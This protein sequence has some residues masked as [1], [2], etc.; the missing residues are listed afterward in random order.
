M[1]VNDVNHQ[2]PAWCVPGRAGTA[3]RRA[4]VTSCPCP[5]NALTEQVGHRRARGVLPVLIRHVPGMAGHTEQ[6]PVHGEETSTAPVPLHGSCGGGRAVGTAQT[7]AG[8]GPPGPWPKRSA[9]PAWPWPA[10]PDCPLTCRR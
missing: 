5:V 2:P 4:A 7:A 6:V 1:V 8:A 10:S 9:R 3:V